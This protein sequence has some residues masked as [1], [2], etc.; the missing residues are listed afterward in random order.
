[1]LI[2]VTGW[3]WE[4]IDEHMTLPRLYEMNDYWAKYPPVHLMLASFFGVTKQEKPLTG[5]DLVQMFPNGVK[6]NG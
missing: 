5:K 6:S 2:M 3:T 1:M 4:Y